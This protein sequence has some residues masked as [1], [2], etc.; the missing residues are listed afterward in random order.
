M[1]SDGEGDRIG[2]DISLH[3]RE[4][5]GKSV[6]FVLVGCKWHTTAAQLC[7]GRRKHY[8]FSN[9]HFF[10]HLLINFSGIGHLRARRKMVKNTFLSNWNEQW[11]CTELGGVNGNG[12][13]SGAPTVYT[14]NI[15]ILGNNLKM[16]E[17]QKY[18]LSESAAHACDVL[19]PAFSMR[20]GHR[21]VG[22]RKLRVNRV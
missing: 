3:W 9:I 11:T 16:N 4:I 21:I 14:D 8:K 15:L 12:N 2:C 20:I 18:A 5:H 6:C 10:R 17:S 1:A 13:G 19:W 7:H 22:Q